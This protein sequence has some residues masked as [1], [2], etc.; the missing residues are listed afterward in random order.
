VRRAPGKA[1]LRVPA[2]C[3][4]GGGESVASPFQGNVR[5]HLAYRAAAQR[6]HGILSRRPT[7]GHREQANKTGKQKRQIFPK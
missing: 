4:L 1:R 5:R 7:G 6:N 3:S 2:W